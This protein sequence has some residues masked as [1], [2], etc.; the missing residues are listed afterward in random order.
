MPKKRKMP[1]KV[2]GWTGH[3]SASPKLQTREILAATSQKAVAAALGLN[4]PNQVFNLVQTGNAGEITKAMSQPGTIFWRPLYS[5][6]DHEW[7]AVPT[8]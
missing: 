8:K 1:L 4:N 5:R 6:N 7:V 3:R 2:F